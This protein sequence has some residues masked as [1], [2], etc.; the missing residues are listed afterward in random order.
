MNSTALSIFLSFFLFFCKFKKINNYFI[1][2]FLALKI[3]IL[4]RFKNF[5]KRKCGRKEEKTSHL[6][7]FKNI[8]QCRYTT[9]VCTHFYLLQLI[10]YVYIISHNKSL[11]KLLKIMMVCRYIR[12]N[13]THKCDKKKCLPVVSSRV[14]LY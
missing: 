5:D 3:L 7:M 4:S 2:F 9:Q 13:I 12:K 8:I 1:L 11:M 14:F 10:Y 6:R